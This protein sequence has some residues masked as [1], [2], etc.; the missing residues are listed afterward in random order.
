MFEKIAFNPLPWYLPPDRR[1]AHT[2]PAL[3]VILK[4]IREA[5]YSAVHADVPVGMSTDSYLSL[6][7]EHGLR[8][9][10][11]YF[12]AELSNVD[13]IPDSVDVARRLAAQHASMG[14]DRI[15]M[16]DKFGVSVE[17]FQR[18]GQG[19]GFEPKRLD[20]IIDGLSKIARVMTE[21]GIVPCLHPHVG[22]WIETWDETVMAMDAISPKNLL[23]GPDPGH[24]AWA[25]MDP[26]ALATKYRDRIGAV[27]LKDIHQDIMRSSR[28]GNLD[29]RQTVS[30]GIWTEPGRGD[31]DFDAFFEALSDYSGW[32][33]V[34]VDVP[35][36]PT[37]EASA[38]IAYEWVNRRL[39]LRQR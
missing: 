7:R 36:Q 8:P 9:A 38:R 39:T 23:L 33:V 29:Y 5:G 21:E 31:I 22:T 37:I 26:G 28:E 32:W 3:P 30:S 20:A 17:R 11:G 10:P 15:F 27:H 25:G 6:L 16:A 1:K 35:D 2:P 19:A 12:Q 4:A 24:L 34:E 13:S 18:P 14:L